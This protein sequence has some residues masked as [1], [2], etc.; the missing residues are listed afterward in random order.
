[1]SDSTPGPKLI[2][3]INE[4]VGALQTCEAALREENIA[5]A[6]LQEAHKRKVE[7]ILADKAELE[8]MTTQ[9]I[10]ANHDTLFA[11]GKKSFTTNSWTFQERTVHT[12]LKIFSQKAVHD[13][14]RNLGIT[15]KVGQRPDAHFKIVAKKLEAWLSANPEYIK[16]FA[17]QVELPVSRRSLTIKRN[18]GEHQTLF[19]NKRLTPSPSIT[20]NLS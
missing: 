13:I 3:D 2:N 9:V 15:R 5:F 16:R 17:S 20:I 11:S 18:G 7:K 4:L 8:R 19:D 1:M 12:G 14:C 6:Q 10:N